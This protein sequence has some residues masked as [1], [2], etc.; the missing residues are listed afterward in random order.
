[1]DLSTKNTTWSFP[2]FSVE[3]VVTG[4]WH[5]NCY[6]LTD[7]YTG[8]ILVIDPG[9]ELDR[10]ISGLSGSVKL[11]DGIVITHGHHDHMGA[12]DELSKASNVLCTIH[13]NDVP[14]FRR[15]P[16]YAM[17]LENKR[18]LTPEKFNTYQDHQVFRFGRSQIQVWWT[19]GH[20][21]GSSCL[22]IEGCLFTGDT[23][24]KETVG[25]SDLPGGNK[26]MLIKSVGRILADLPGDEVIYPGHGKDWTIGEAREWWA[27]A[28]ESTFSETVYKW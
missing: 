13:N 18:V 4:N 27:Y 19:P 24:F 17:T 15:A 11:I 23:L 25:R 6:L 10:I 8:R 16:L 28:S 5:E 21:P 22:Y 2:G 3:R 20:T 9:D 26:E 7:T 12:A 14:L 1:M